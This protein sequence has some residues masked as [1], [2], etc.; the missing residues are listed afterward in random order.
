M[1]MNRT[2][3]FLFVLLFMVGMVAHANAQY[4][5]R[6]RGNI[7]NYGNYY[8]HGG[9]RGGSHGKGSYGRGRGFR[10]YG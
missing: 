2:I 4:R 7:R 6:S 10:R 5:S 9:Q 8:G 3:I 1:I